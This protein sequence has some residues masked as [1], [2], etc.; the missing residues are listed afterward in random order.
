MTKSATK[1]AAAMSLA[2]LI[3]IGVNCFAVTPYFNAA[4]SSGAFNSFGL[5]AGPASGGGV[6]GGFIWTKK[7]GAQG[8]DN[9]GTGLLE[10]GNV[11]IVW[12]NSSAPTKVCSY[13]AV[14]SIIGQQLFFAAPAST[15][16]ILFAAGTSGDNLIPTLTD[17]P[18]PQAVINVLQG[19][20]FN[21]APTDVRPEDALFEET[22]VLAPLDTVHY[23]GL[24][25][26]PGPVGVSIKSAFS[27]KTSTPAIYALSGTD[28]ITGQTI[29]ATKTINVGV[30]VMVA[31]VNA[32]QGSGQNSGHFG[33]ST[34]F[35]NINRRDWTLAMNGG[36]AYTKD[37]T[38]VPGQGTVPL[39]VIAREPLSGTYTTT[40]FN[41][42]RNAETASTQEL[43]VNPATGQG[44]TCPGQPCG[45]PLFLSNGGGWRK[46]AIGNGEEV[47]EVGTAANGDSIGYAFWSVGN[48][49][50]QSPNI[51]YMQV[52]GVDPIN[53]SYIDGTLP[54]CSAPCPGI[55]SFANVAS[56]NYP[57]WQVLTVVSHKPIPAGVTA[58]I[59]GAQHQVVDF[60]PDFLPLSAMGVLRSHYKQSGIGAANGS[61]GG[62]NFAETG[63]DVG[64]AVIT[65]Q[66]DQDYCAAT[67]IHTGRNGLKQ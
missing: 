55:V 46:R 34:S 26:G 15:F 48:L 51:R 14:D 33:D 17:T 7:N 4:G 35:F 49:A 67:G 9:R 66:G 50:G 8:V 56:G 45:N 43:N 44:T 11:W 25:Y 52:D 62:C 54:T 31:I 38:S 22:R 6:C 41:I 61:G 47:A 39:N 64:G 13:I 30:Q 42:P 60:L 32:Q 57:V 27:T 65:I 10:T 24:G 23:N 37:L 19:Q 20:P 28:P 21:A 40:E 12:D 2:L 1:M 58:L 53:L 63:G 18:I 29:P 3:F 36:Y 5:A 16:N 59:A